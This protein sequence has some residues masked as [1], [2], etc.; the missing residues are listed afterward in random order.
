[1]VVVGGLASVW[2][3]LF[4][5]A[6]ITLLPHWLEFLKDYFELLH[7]ALLVL[8]L[9][10]LPQGLVTGLWD[11]LQLR[12]ARRRLADLHTEK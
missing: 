10:F 4:G 5:T 8:I 6:L 9:L 11:L 3:T 12:L 7:G 1:M 2:G